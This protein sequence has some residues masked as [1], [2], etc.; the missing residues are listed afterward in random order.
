M[1]SLYFS[2]L[3]K[4]SALSKTIFFTQSQCPSVCVCVCVCVCVLCGVCVSLRVCL[5]LCLCLCAQDA[6]LRGVCVCVC[7]SL[8]LNLG[9][10]TQPSETWMRLS[11]HTARGFFAAY[12]CCKQGSIPIPSDARS[13]PPRTR[14]ICGA[15]PT[16]SIRT[17]TPAAQTHTAHN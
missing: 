8:P 2:F 5:C 1:A 12:S 16:R 14:V 15:L 17:H 7:A 9:W 13:H 4:V 11:H 6:D 10:P 3:Y